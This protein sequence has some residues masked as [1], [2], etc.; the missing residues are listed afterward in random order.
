MDGVCGGAEGEG[1]KGI[2]CEW[3]VA[4][5][6][7]QTDSHQ[8]PQI[9]LSPGTILLVIPL[10]F[11]PLGCRIWFSEWAAQSNIFA[12]DVTENFVRISEL[13]LFRELKL[14]KV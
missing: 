2:D 3:W 13:K 12:N 11:I 10:G 8:S 5:A 7:T 1:G 9:C 4:V 14:I 6:H